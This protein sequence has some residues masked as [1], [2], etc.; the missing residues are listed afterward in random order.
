MRKKYSFITKWELQAPL[1][2][3]WDLIY[4]SLE[5]PQWWPGVTEVIEIKKNDV[6]GINGI[7]CYTWKS[8]LP[9]K[10]TFTMQL[11]EKEHLRHMKGVAFGE[12]EGQG[13]W[14]FVQ[15]NG[16][17]YVQYNWDVFTNK[18]WMNYFSFFL[19]PVF[20]INHNIV[21]HWG[22]KGLARKLNTTLLKG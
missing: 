11:T 4:N 7:R 1:E 19:K 17:V 3:V 10:L 21:M 8:F 9:Y 2:Q 5:W 20:K 18:K 15:Q 13:E 12:L 16:V 14:F 22:A 6:N